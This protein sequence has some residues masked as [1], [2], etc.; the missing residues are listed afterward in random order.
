V[1][2]SSDANFRQQLMS[3]GV[4]AAYRALMRVLDD[5]K[6]TSTALASAARTILDVAGLTKPTDADKPKEPHEMTAEE[7][8]AAISRLRTAHDDE[9]GD[10]VFE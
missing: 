8:Q 1:S 9:D 5:P 4:P 3:E 10:G 7:I 2:K 6:S